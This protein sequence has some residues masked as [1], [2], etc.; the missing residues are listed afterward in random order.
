M[1]PMTTPFGDRRAVFHAFDVNFFSLPFL[2]SSSFHQLM[3]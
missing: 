3:E 1:L 2:K